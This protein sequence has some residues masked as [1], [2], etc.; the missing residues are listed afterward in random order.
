M[1]Q[2]NVIVRAVKRG[3]R[4]RVFITSSAGPED[5]LCLSR[6][7]D[8]DQVVV[9]GDGQ[10]FIH[11]SADDLGDQVAA[12]MAALPATL[13]DLR[14]SVSTGRVVDFRVREF[15]RDKPGPE[16]APLIWPS[17]FACGT[18]AWPKEGVRKPEA[19]ALAER[20][21][22]QLVPNGP[23]VLVRRFSAKEERRRVVAAV[24]DPD[25]VPGPVVGF[26]NHLNYIHRRGAGLDIELARGLAAFLNSTLVDAY[27]RQFNGHT[28]VNAT[29]L[30]SLH[31]PAAERLRSLGAAVGRSTTAG[32][33]EL[34]ALIEQEVF[35]MVAEPRGVDAIKAK[36]W[37]D[38]ALEV[39]KALGLPR[40]QQNE[41]SAL[42]LLA[43]LDLKPGTPWARARDPL[44]GIRP[45]MDFF[46]EQYGKRYAENTRESVRRLTVHQLLDAGLIVVNP[47]D[48]KQP[49]NSGQTVYQV[50]RSA[51]KLV[52]TFGRRD[53]EKNLRAYLVAVQPLVKR[54]A[55]ERQMQRMPLRL[56]S[57]K[58]IMLSPGGQNVLVAKI[59]TDFAEY[60]TPGGVPLYVGDTD[61]KFAHFDREGLASLGID[62]EPHGK[63]PDVIIHYTDR[64]WL[65][66]VEAVTSHGPINPK[67]RDE[68]QRSLAGSRAG[69]ICVTAFL[70]RRALVQWLGDISWETEVWVAESPT[71]MIH[72][73][74]ERFLGPYPD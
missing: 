39:L 44:R 12:R 68:L 55:R 63:M 21:R 66:V 9:P 4:A 50:E 28:Q 20:T 53:W 16:T 40:G 31:C 34:D 10:A 1:L 54:Y 61:E 56:P 41:R 7:V 29:D 67:R 32:Q 17:H 24:C 47:D 25:R 49:T 46:A 27:F 60:F 48:P 51:L 35:D 18:I 11:I 69:L 33:A 58:K 71:H 65:V 52:R 42:T 30:R 59:V 19:I 57:G 14:L 72:F 26:E 13:A 15:L 74:G 62:I 73:N 38:E 37:I 36:R 8:A 3:R 5:E 22:D 23:Y 6:V 70:T 43:L 2:E 64:N 45:M